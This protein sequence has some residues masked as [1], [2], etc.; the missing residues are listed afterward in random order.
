MPFYLS[1]FAHALKSRLQRAFGQ[2]D[3]AGSRHVL[4]NQGLAAHRRDGQRCAAAPDLIPG[5]REL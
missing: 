1:P 4:V 3:A 5:W 2:A